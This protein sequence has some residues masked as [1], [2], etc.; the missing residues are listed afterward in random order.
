MV[1]SVKVGTPDEDKFVREGLGEVEVNL[2]HSH[3][4][5]PQPL[6]KWDLRKK[7]P[8]LRKEAIPIG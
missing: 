7:Q 4:C 2:Q 5:P 6:K 3:F 1:A 8:L